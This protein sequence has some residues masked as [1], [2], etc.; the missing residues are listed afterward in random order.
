MRMEE[1]K[2]A[3]VTPWPLSIL[4]LNLVCSSLDP[5]LDLHGGGDSCLTYIFGFGL[6]R[7]SPNSLLAMIGIWETTALRIHVRALQVS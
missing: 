3:K 5:G 4:A 7:T 6:H 2:T 1:G